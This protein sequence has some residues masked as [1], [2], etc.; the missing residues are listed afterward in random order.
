MDSHS[1]SRP[2]VVANAA[3][4]TWQVDVLRQGVPEP[5]GVLT[6]DAHTLPP[7]RRKNK[8][9]WQL[10]DSVVAT[11]SF[12][13]ALAVEPTFGTHEQKRLWELFKEQKK[14]RRKNLVKKKDSGDVTV[15][16]EASF[17]NTANSVSTTTTSNAGTESSRTEPDADDEGEEATKSAVLRVSSDIHVDT[18][19]PPVRSSMVP[20]FVPPPPP[21]FGVSGMARGEQQEP[22]PNLSISSTASQAHLPAPPGIPARPNPIPDA[23]PTPSYFAPPIPSAPETLAASVVQTMLACLPRG[24][25]NGWMRFYHPSVR[26]AL[27]VGSAQAVCH[28]WTDA[29]TQWQSLA[30]AAPS[31]P[32]SA[33]Q[34]HGC[35]TQIVSTGYTGH[36]PLSTASPPSYLLTITGRTVQKQQETLNFHLSLILSYSSQDGNQGGYQIC[37][38]VLSLVPLAARP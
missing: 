23:L 15:T 27:L 1:F 20:S 30:P 25:V 29:Y 34:V 21:G 33:W 9:V 36:E 3:H 17:E 11:S 28:G 7:R 22:S 2:R 6:I 38:D 18:T 8:I 35:H 4:P 31:S 26:K 16:A 24:D 32:S 37:N 5:V 19:A 14:T 13:K 10:P 12:G